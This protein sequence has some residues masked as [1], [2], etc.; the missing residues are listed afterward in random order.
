[1][2]YFGVLMLLV[3]CAVVCEAAALPAPDTLSPDV[4]YQAIVE[5]GA[6]KA[7]LSPT[8]TFLKAIVAGVFIAFGGLLALSVGANC[9]GMHILTRVLLAYVSECDIQAK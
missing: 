7:T 9:P 4:T 1:M 6:K 8:E 2:C 5:M 3:C